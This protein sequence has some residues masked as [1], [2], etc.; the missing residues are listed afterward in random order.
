MM[1]QIFNDS[2]KYI[3]KIKKAQRLAEYETAVDLVLRDLEM[4]PGAGF[5][6]ERR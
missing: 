1:I 5:L 6:P 3:K 4:I 2:G